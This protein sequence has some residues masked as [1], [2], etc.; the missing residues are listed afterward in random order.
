[1]GTISKLAGGSREASKESLNG[2][3]PKKMTKRLIF[4]TDALSADSGEEKPK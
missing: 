1:M 3:S 4:R 2:S